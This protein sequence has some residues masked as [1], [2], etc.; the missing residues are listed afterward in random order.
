MSLLITSRWANYSYT[1][2]A[3]D[4]LWVGR[5]VTGLCNHPLQCTTSLHV[6]SDFAISWFRV[7]WSWS[8][9]CCNSTGFLQISQ[10]CELDRRPWR[11][12]FKIAILCRSLCSS[13]KENIKLSP[14]PFLSGSME[15]FSPPQINWPGN[16][17]Q[18]RVPLL[19]YTIKEAFVCLSVCRHFSW[20]TN[21]S[22]SNFQKLISECRGVFL[23]KTI[24][25]NF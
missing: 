7:S 16:T 12:I 18:R 14:T 19:V 5:G 23:A 20:L 13:V 8:L 24:L 9:D 6:R 11:A 22:S 21:G 17:R 25:S 15:A 2:H 4:D 1:D 3:N 10:V